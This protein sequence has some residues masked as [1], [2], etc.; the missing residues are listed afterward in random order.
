ML[1]SRKNVVMFSALA[2]VIIA[3]SVVLYGLYGAESTDNPDDAEL[4]S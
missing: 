2:V 1:K 4:A 3:G